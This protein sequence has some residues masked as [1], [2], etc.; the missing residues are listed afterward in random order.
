MQHKVI[1]RWKENMQFDSVVEGHNVKLDASPD[2]GGLG[3][4]ARPKQLLLSALAGCTG[5]DVISILTKMRHLPEH[6]NIIVEGRLTD[7]QPRYYESMHIIYEFGGNGLDMEKL[8]RSVELSQEKYC[9]VYY[10]FSKFATIT[11]EIKIL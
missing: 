3:Q 10:M 1:T 5:I 8:K 9:G 4:G 6:F 11:H 7:E 2:F